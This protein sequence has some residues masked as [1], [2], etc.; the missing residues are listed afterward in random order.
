MDALSDVLSLLKLHSYGCGGCDGC[1]FTCG[2][3]DRMWV[4]GS[5]RSASS[6]ER[7]CTGPLKGFGPTATR[8]RL[9]PSASRGASVGTWSAEAPLIAE[10][11]EAAEAATRGSTGGV[12][13]EE[14]RCGL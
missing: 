2:G 3:G 1:G 12:A 5:A 9:S 4:G 13:I 6:S 8:G 10:N 7:V 14:L 11:M